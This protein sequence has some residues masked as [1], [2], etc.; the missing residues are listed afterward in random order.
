MAWTA[1]PAPDGVDHYNVYRD[2]TAGFT[3]TPGPTPTIATPATNSYSDTG[4]TGSTT[5]YYKVTAVDAAGNI[6]PLSAEVSASTPAAPD[7]T[8]PS[9]VT[10]LAA[11][12]GEQ[13]SN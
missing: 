11:Y 5:Y 13:H 4:L 6:G 10:G 2:T 9:Q 8:P 1:S 12:S 3:V 7:T